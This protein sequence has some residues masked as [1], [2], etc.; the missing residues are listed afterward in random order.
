[1][2]RPAVTASRKP[3]VD[4]VKDLA[5]GLRRALQESGWSERGL[6]MAAGC[7]PDR[8]RNVGRGLSSTL[9]AEV[10]SQ[11]A[12][13]LAVPAASLIGEQ[14]WPDQGARLKRSEPPQEQVAAA[15]VPGSL[16]ELAAEARRVAVEARVAVQV[17]IRAAEAAERIA[18]RVEAAA[19]VPPETTEN[20]FERWI[21]DAE[22][23]AAARPVPPAKPP[24]PPAGPPPSA[25]SRV[26]PVEP[27]P[28]AV[29]PGAPQPVPEVLPETSD[30]HEERLWRHPRYPNTSVLVGFHRV[31]K[32]G[33]VPRDPLLRLI[34]YFGDAPHRVDHERKQIVLSRSLRKGRLENRFDCVAVGVGEDGLFQVVDLEDGA[35]IVG[36]SADAEVAAWGA[37]DYQRH[38]ETR[39][40]FRDLYPKGCEY[41]KAKGGGDWAEY[42]VGSLVEDTLK[43]KAGDVLSSL[44]RRYDRL[45]D[46]LRLGG[47]QEVTDETAQMG[48][49]AKEALQLEMRGS[50]GNTLGRDARERVIA[51][52]RSVVAAMRAHLGSL[53]GEARA[54]HLANVCAIEC[55]ADRLT[56]LWDETRVTTKR[57]AGK[58]K[59]SKPP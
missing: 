32:T 7:K 6:S 30:D 36:A 19:A 46:P 16:F 49:S 51:G 10:M 48:K 31:R 41:I 40:G 35:K 23:E 5:A 27:T 11:V 56:E 12:D 28:A 2:K 44:L 3:K 42:A 52:I 21:S 43:D 22:A 37:L 17:A 15:P 24:A 13:V 55:T 14:P 47:K 8:L 58:A 34:W 57:T 59:P 1:M 25:A 29:A 4:R 33:R 53:R 18:A 45:Q 26:Q 54:E 39:A 50:T 9:P 20:V 38:S